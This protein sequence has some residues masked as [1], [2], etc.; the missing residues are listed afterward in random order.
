[1]GHQIA[2]VKTARGIHRMIMSV[3]KEG[4]GKSQDFLAFLLF[5]LMSTIPLIFDKMEEQK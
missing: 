5:A 2:K 1:M 3:K 4:T